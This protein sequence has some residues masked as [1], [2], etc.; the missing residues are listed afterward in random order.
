VPTTQYVP[1]S[2]KISSSA[3]SNGIQAV[4]YEGA[5]PLASVGV[6]IKG[7]SSFE[8]H[9]TAGVFHFLKHMALKVF[10]IFSFSISLPTKSSSDP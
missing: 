9:Q 8:T 2:D 7:G 5:G 10:F 6:V 4:S 3:L 1:P